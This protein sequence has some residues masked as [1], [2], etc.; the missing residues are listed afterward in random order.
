M[1]NPLKA[2]RGNALYLDTMMPYLFLRGVN[3][4][5]PL[6]QR[7]ERGEILAYTSALTFDELGYR[8]LLAFIKDRYEGSPLERLR[9][10]E[11]RMMA[12]FA[13]PVASLLRRLREY[14]YLTVVDV[15]ASDLDVMGETMVRFHLRPRDAL[16]Y[17]AM[18]RVGCLDLASNDP[19]FDRIP[20]IRRFTL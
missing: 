10:Q 7:I 16:H 8:L 9:D 2:F 6:F 1:A 3:E 17:A 20:T 19:H 12:E 15:L 13:P 11:E 14:P 18:L 5:R 4:F